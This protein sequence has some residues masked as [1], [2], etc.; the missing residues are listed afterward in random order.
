MKNQTGGGKSDRTAF[1]GLMKPEII[2][3]GMLFVKTFKAIDSIKKSC[4]KV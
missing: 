3:A 2:E 1:L 4:L